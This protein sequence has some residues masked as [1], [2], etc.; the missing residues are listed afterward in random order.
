MDN[1]IQNG[2]LVIGSYNCR[3]FNSSKLPFIRLLL[4][5]CNIVLIQEHWLD[6]SQ[7]H[8]LEKCDPEFLFTGVSGFDNSEVLTG[9]PFGGCMIF[10]RMH[11][12]FVVS[13]LA[14]K[15]NRVCAICLN[16]DDVK[17]LCIN[18]YMPYEDSELSLDEFF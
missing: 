9:R 17:L 18:V 13:V 15:S 11:S 3:G 5:K 2:L 10:W 7:L 4:S 16:A 1:I 6:S 14:T 8:V 12:H